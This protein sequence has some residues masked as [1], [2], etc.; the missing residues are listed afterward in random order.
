MIFAISVILSKP[1]ANH[2][3]EQF[4]TRI[5]TDSITKITTDTPEDFIAALHQRYHYPKPFQQD[6]DKVP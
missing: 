5:R 3:L 1:P 6:A 4:R 2:D